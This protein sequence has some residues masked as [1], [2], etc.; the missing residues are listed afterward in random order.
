MSGLER[1]YGFLYTV[2]AQQEIQAKGILA[3][4]SNF[5]IIKDSDFTIS[6][7]IIND[8]IKDKNSI[9][10]SNSDIIKQKSES[11]FDFDIKT[12]I[13]LPLIIKSQDSD[14]DLLGVLYLDKQ[15]TS[16]QLPKKLSTNL[17]LI[18]SMASSAIHRL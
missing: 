10:I 14:K 4:N 5:K 3:K 15:F 2:N 16:H 11:M 13:C 12:V 18:S 8:T 7:S 1:A 17:K 6:Q 9:Y